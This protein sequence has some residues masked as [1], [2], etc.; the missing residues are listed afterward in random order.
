MTDELGPND[1]RWEIIHRFLDGLSP[2]P[3]RRK[4]ERW[5]AGDLS[6]QRYIKAHKKVWSMIARCVGPEP[7]DPEEAW[8]SIQ[9]R[10]AEHD[11]TQRFQ[12]PGR[13]REHLRVE[14]GGRGSTQ[15]PID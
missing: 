8:E 4:V 14:D 10:V 6:V 15:I 5:M 9:D 2:L 11:R 13:G 3:E 7:V 1:S 12:L